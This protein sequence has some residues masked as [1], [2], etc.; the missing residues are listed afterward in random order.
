VLL[1]YCTF[2]KSLKRLAKEGLLSDGEPFVLHRTLE[3]AEATCRAPDGRR[4]HV[5]VL[6]PSRIGYARV[7]WRLRRP[8]V[9]S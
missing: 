1:F 4:G 2:E 9:T 5:L 3:E 7:R 6:E 8:V